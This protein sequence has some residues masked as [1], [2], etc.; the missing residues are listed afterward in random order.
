MKSLIKKILK[1]LGL[2][3]FCRALYIK[4]VHHDYKSERRFRLIQN[5]E[6]LFNL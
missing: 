4:I 3:S 2:L 6:G 5:Q 1:S